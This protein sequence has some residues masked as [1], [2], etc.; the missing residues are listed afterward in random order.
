[1]LHPARVDDALTV[2]TWVEDI[3]RVRSHRSYEVRGAGGILCVAART[4]WVYVDAATYRPRRVPVEMERAFG[5]EPGAPHTER[6]DWVAPPPP[7]VP[8]RS[9]YQVPYA[10]LDSLGHVNNA[11]YLDVLAEAALGALADVGWPLDRLAAD[12]AVPW[13]AEG[14]L[15]YLDAARHRDRLEALTWFGASTEA[16]AV[17]QLLTRADDGQP[18]VRAGTRWRWA[19]PA[20]AAPTAP[21]PLLGAALRPLLAA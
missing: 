5:L 2:A 13:L 16:L 15:E 14:D 9:A 20:T 10:D 11:T 18:L 21:P 12:G 3:R 4:D 6:P 7:P 17:H 1:V 8:A 19:D